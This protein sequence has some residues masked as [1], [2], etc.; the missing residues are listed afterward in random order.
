MSESAHRKVI[1]EP[2]SD[3]TFH[4][5]SKFIQTELGIKMPDTKKTMLQ[6]RLQKRL[7]KLEMSSFDDYCDY[8]FSHE[9]MENE[10]QHMINVV[11]TNKTEFFR[12]PKH[13]E[14]LA[15][16]VLPEIVQKRGFA[17][18]FMV[19]CAGCSTGEEPYSLAMVLNEF[20]ERNR[21]FR[22]LILATDI[23]SKVLDQAKLGIYEEE[24]IESVPMNLRKKYLL[25]SKTTDNGLVRIIPEL[26]AR[27]RFR[28]LNF[29]D[30]NFG[31]RELMDMVFCRNV[32][33]YFDRPTQEG[34]LNRICSYL[35]P[36]GY[37]FTGH[38]ETLN[39]MKLPLAPVS[40][41]VYRHVDAAGGKEQQELPIIYL[42][43]AEMCITDKPSVVRTVLGSCLAITM[44]HPRL[45]VAAICHAL[46][47]EPDQQSAEENAPVN[48]LKYVTL[49]I[50]EMI[51]KLQEYGIK[52]EELEVKMFGGAD[53][54]TTRE[55]RGKNQAVGRLNSMKAVMLLESH[56]LKVKVSDVGGT[57]GRKIFF[58]THTGEV[59]LKRLTSGIF[60]QETI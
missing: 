48:P 2:M 58:Y 36:G 5:F 1:S 49:V 30:R 12:E 19:W 33:I 34:V 11:T 6:A 50:P 29:M 17:D 47:P 13:F 25:R 31:L 43:P 40:H 39:G 41:T 27:I 32:I 20:A 15:E 4:R 3:R 46:L 24:R 14:Y 52:L 57:L 16:R 10:L 9:G 37:L 56:G 18:T 7:W 54:L 21:E 23:S 42:K 28:R 35:R 59:L 44:F 51:A 60:P 26:R 38:S 55:D 22:F 53:M 8:L 45:G